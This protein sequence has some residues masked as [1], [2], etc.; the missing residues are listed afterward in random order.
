MGIWMVGEL[1]TG[2][3]AWALP[4]DCNLRFFLPEQLDTMTG[5]ASEWEADV[6][7]TITEFPQ[8]FM[9]G[10][11]DFSDAVMVGTEGY[12]GI[13]CD[14]E[15]DGTLDNVGAYYPELPPELVMLPADGIE[16]GIVFL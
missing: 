16:L 10:V 4:M 9:L 13:R 8:P 5:V 6:P 3:G 1:Q 2:D 12:V 11:D 7:I 14:L 15:G